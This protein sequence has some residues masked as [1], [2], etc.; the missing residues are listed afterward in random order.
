MTCFKVKNA[1][2]LDRLAQLLSRRASQDEEKF[3]KQSGWR[4]LKSNRGGP[5]HTHKL[6]KNCKGL[7]DCVWRLQILVLHQAQIVISRIATSLWGFRSGALYT[8]Y[9]HMWFTY[10]SHKELGEDSGIL[11]AAPA[12]SSWWGP[13]V[14]LQIHI[15]A[16]NASTLPFMP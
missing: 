5:L 16:K 6:V 9:S 14:P 3:Y 11:S 7:S 4:A 2:L 13:N 1:Y 15:Q 12:I 8:A 10:F